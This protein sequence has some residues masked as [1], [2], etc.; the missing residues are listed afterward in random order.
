MFGSGSDASGC[1]WAVVIVGEDEDE[2]LPI[3]DV[4]EKYAD[5]GI[6]RDGMEAT[7]AVTKSVCV[8]I[9]GLTAGSWVG[10]CGAMTGGTVAGLRRR[11]WTGTLA[12]DTLLAPNGLG[13]MLLKLN[14]LAKPLL[15]EAGASTD[16]CSSACESLMDARIDAAESKTDGTDWSNCSVNFERL[17]L[18]SQIGVHV[19]RKDTY[20]EV[21]DEEIE[22]GERDPSRV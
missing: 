5:V 13:L 2:E 20:T 8:W 1:S 16:T 22:L 19:R 10:E 18:S 12:A 17:A 15:R 6:T 21:G 14:G 7:V 11:L 4:V 3:D 9:I